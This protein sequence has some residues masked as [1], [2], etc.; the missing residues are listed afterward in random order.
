MVYAVRA[1]PANLMPPTLRS[2]G[3][4]VRTCLESVHSADCSGLR[5]GLRQELDSYLAAI[6]HEAY[7]RILPSKASGEPER[8]SKYR[9]LVVRAAILAQD[10]PALSEAAKRLARKMQRPTE[11]TSA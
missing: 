4:A 5:A 1:T 2:F 3:D 7:R 8:I 10:R 9:S 11:L 6:N